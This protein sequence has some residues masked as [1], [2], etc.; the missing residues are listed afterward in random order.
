LRTSTVPPARGKLFSRFLA[1]NSNGM[2]FAAFP[3]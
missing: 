1:S 2:G 3:L